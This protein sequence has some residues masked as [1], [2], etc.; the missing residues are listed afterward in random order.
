L[1]YEAAVKERG[2]PII[3][4]LKNSESPIPYMHIFALF[5]FLKQVCDHPALAA[6]RFEEY[7]SYSSG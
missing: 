5:S 3:E 7:E 4:Q 2:G 1:I 6:G